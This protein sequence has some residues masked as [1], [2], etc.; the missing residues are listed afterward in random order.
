MPLY[1]LDLLQNASESLSESLRR[2]GDHLSGDEA[3]IKHSVL[4]LGHFIELYLKHCVSKQHD[5]LIFKNPSAEKVG[6]E[7]AETITI[8]SAMAI[9]KNCK[10]S[11]PKPLLDDITK[12]RK[13][14]NAI[15]HYKV[16]VDPEEFLELIGKLIADLSAWDASNIKAGINTLIAPDK[17]Q[18]I[19]Q[20]VTDQEAKLQAAMEC[21]S[22]FN[23]QSGIDVNTTCSD[24]GYE[25]AYIHPDDESELKCAYCDATHFA[26]EC[27][28]CGLHCAEDVMHHFAD[29]DEGVEVDIW[30]CNKCGEEQAYGDYLCDLMMDE[31]ARN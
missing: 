21:A 13:K 17:W 22:K 26:F 16:S 20:N 27:S 10:I 7:E 28:S 23:E 1:E 8:D 4:Y 24:C 30:T 29:S 5:L 25:T 12:I 15:M 31:R 9:L 3:A 6:T 2:Y 18:I 19:A 14:R 11:I